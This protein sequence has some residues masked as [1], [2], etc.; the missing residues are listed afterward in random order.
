MAG[1][2]FAGRLSSFFW[3]L[4]IRFF[5]I[6]LIKQKNNEWPVEVSPVALAV[7]SSTCKNKPYKFMVLT[8]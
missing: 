1:A 4:F 3:L 2:E 7:T 5:Q 8:Q 6:A